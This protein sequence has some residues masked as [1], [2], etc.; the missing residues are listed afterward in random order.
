MQI[1]VTVHALTLHGGAVTYAVTV[2]DHLQRLGHDVWLTTPQMGEAAAPAR[3]L[4][5]RVVGLDALPPAP[6]VIVSQ[7]AG[8]RRPQRHL[9]LPAAAGAARRRRRGRHAV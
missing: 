7:D 5:L 4:G 3:E 9:R 2:A 8:L 1:V 6:E